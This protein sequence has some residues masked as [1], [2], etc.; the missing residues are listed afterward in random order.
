M[1]RND[2]LPGDKIGVSGFL[3]DSLGGFLSLQKNKNEDLQLI[4]KHLKPYP[5]L[6]LA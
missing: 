6:S 1:T 4:S 3:G 5:N 2:A